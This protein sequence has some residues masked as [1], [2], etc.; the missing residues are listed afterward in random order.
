MGSTRD[1]IA[2]FLQER[3]DKLLRAD[4]QVA[5][6][7]G[8]ADKETYAALLRQFYIYVRVTVPALYVTY[9]KL[10]VDHP[11]VESMREAVMGEI[12][13]EKLVL[14]DLAAMGL[15]MTPKEADAIATPASLAMERFHMMAAEAGVIPMRCVGLLLEAYSARG[16]PSTVKG[17]EKAGIPVSAQEF[18]R[19]HAEED[20]PHTERAIDLLAEMATTPQVLQQIFHWLDTEAVLFEAFLRQAWETSPM[21][22]SKTRL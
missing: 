13:H 20:G 2:S 10:P 9:S 19:L 15:P 1:L 12:G 7:N 4:I 11:N 3:V 8:T 6:D 17:M 21:G 18:M 16:S 5:I 14:M 22:R